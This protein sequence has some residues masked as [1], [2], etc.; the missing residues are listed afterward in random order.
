VTAPPPNSGAFV[1]DPPAS[2]PDQA[3]PPRNVGVVYATDYGLKADGVELTDVVLTASSVALVSASAN[4]TSLDIG[5]TILINT[6]SVSMAGTLAGTSGSVFITG[7]GTSFLTEFDGSNWGQPGSGAVLRV[8]GHDYGVAGVFT[9]TLLQVTSLHASTFS[10]ATAYKEL[11]LKTY[12]VASSGTSCQIADAPLLSGSGL[13]AFYGTDNSSSLDDAITAA[14]ETGAGL[15]QMPAGIIGVGRNL[16]Y[17]S[18]SRLTIAGISA[19]ST[20]LKELRAAYEEVVYTDPNAAMLCFRNCSL[21]E[22]RDFSVDASLPVRCYG[23]SSGGGVNTNGGRIG[24]MLYNCTN[25]GYRRMGTRGFGS[26]DELFCGSGTCVGWYCID[27]KAVANNVGINLNTSNGGNAIVVSGNAIET[28]FTPLLLGGGSAVVENNVFSNVDGYYIGADMIV[29]D[30]SARITFANNIVRVGR[31]ETASV[32]C[33]KVFGSFPSTDSI[34]NIT[35][36]MFTDV[37]GSFNL[38]CGLIQFSN[39]AGVA[40]VSNNIVSNC[41]SATAGGRCVYVSG[42]DTR[43]ISVS[44][45]TFDCLAGSNMSVGIFGDGTNP[46]GTVTQSANIFGA[47]ITTASTGI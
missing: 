12:I 17:E 45:N 28:P 20:C 44:G 14:L 30:C 36:N 18:R 40:R 31:L 33:V 10:G 9:D 22:L 42:G 38:P 43:A 5:K 13:T 47:S 16:L 34:I 7:T 41:S 26:R 29:L 35:G 2:E 8:N 27:C 1:T 11:Q 39:F 6:P 3:E 25:S 24:L 23:H 19:Q 32:A 4:F 37:R 15:V 21:I 46:V